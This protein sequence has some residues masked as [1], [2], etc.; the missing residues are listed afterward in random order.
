MEY[1]KYI[2]DSHT[3]KKAWL[4]IMKGKYQFEDIDTTGG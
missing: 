3:S 2:G 4:E 1:V